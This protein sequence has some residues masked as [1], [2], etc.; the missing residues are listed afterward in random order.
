M[1]ASLLVILILASL[2]LVITSPSIA[3]T[4]LVPDDYADIQDAIDEAVD[5]DVVEVSEGTYIENINFMGKAITVTAVDGPDLTIID[6][7]ADGTVVTFDSEEDNERS[8]WLSLP[9]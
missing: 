6:G 7:D 3:E 4:L 5:G 9:S 8:S 2:S 1:N